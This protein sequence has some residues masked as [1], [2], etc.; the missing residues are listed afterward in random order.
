MKPGITGPWQA[1]KRSDTQDYRE[2]VE[3]DRNYVLNC[4]LWMDLKIIF[5]TAWRV[6][7]PRGAY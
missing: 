6:L 7:R 3:M 1:G 5:M 4:S 2:R